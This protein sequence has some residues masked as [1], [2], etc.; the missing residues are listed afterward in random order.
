MHKEE[1]PKTK[2]EQ[3]KE[4]R[5]NPMNVPKSEHDRLLIESLQKKSEEYKIL[6]DSLTKEIRGLRK[7]KGTNA[8]NKKGKVKQIKE[9]RAEEG[10]DTWKFEES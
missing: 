10:N 2:K 3:L 4:K 1:K 5:K 7:E 6:N 9:E 8:E